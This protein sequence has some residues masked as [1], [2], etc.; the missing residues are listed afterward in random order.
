MITREDIRRVLDDQIAFHEER[1]LEL[2]R[3]GGRD[4]WGIHRHQQQ[5]EDLRKF[6]G[7][8]G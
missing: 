7:D 1:I 5:I 8:V 3:D 2:S 4:E 6:E